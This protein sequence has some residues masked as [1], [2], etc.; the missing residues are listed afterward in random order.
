MKNI[1]CM[2][3]LLFAWITLLCS[4]SAPSQIA[5]YDL[6]AANG[7]ELPLESS[8]PPFTISTTTDADSLFGCANHEPPGAGAGLPDVGR[9]IA[10]FGPPAAVPAR[11][12]VLLLALTLGLAT[13]AWITLTRRRL[14]L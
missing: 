5:A 10:V 14:A 2:V 9:D 4:A 6:F 7:T 12:Q 13:V 1:K 8:A 3:G 11:S